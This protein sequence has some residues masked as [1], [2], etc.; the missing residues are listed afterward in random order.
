[1]VNFSLSQYIPSGATVKSRFTTAK[2]WEL[3]KQESALAPKD[4]WTNADSE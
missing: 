3:E 4:V 1:M 2:A